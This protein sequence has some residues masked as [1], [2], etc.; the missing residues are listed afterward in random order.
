MISISEIERL[1]TLSNKAS[2]LR[3]ALVSQIQVCEQH[4]AH[5]ESEERILD[6]VAALLRQLIDTEVTEGVQAVESLQTEGLRE[7]FHDQNLSVKAEVE[8][9]RGRI[10]VTLMTGREFQDG[11]VVWGIAEDSFGGSVFTM[12]SILM[13]I[14]VIFRR[15]MR[16]LLLLDETLA[17]VS[18]K[19]VDRAAQFLSQLCDKLNLDILL[20][21]HDEAVVGMAKNAYFVTY[22]D[23]QAR[24]RK[25]GKKRR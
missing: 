24:F 8:E 25:L 23:D 7:I 22:E 18:N 17:A 6:L 3:D 9:S 1:Q 19:Y 11:T 12:Q 20:I 15:S 2:G 5:L 14:T 21:T 16:P 13:R 4:L 10:S